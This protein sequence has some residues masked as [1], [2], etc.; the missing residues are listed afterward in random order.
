MG[1]SLVK[2][3]IAYKTTYSIFAIVHR[4]WLVTITSWL[5]S[6]QPITLLI[7]S[8]SINKNAWVQLKKY[9]AE[10]TFSKLNSREN[11]ITATLNSVR[12]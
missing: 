11:S 5:G 3:T 9:L 7:W 1:V 8:E 2:T 12:S 10:K 4:R 6:L